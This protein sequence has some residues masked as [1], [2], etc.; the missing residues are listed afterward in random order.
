MA[1]VAAAGP[2]VSWPLPPPPWVPDTQPHT[3]R[4]DGG[5]GRADSLCPWRTSPS[6]RRLL[7]CNGV[8]HRS[9]GPSSPSCTQ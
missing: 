6:S 7:Y 3:D 2:A 8:N 4:Q 9:I 1:S 5:P